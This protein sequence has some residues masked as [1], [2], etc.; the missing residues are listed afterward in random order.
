MVKKKH[1]GSKLSDFLEEDG[2]KDDVDLLTFKK[3]F[4][5]EIEH[6]MAALNFTTTTL[7]K[8][9]DTSRNQVLRILDGADIGISFKTVADVARALSS[10]FIEV[11]ASTSKKASHLR[12]PPKRSPP[13]QR[14]NTS[15]A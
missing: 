7:A 4:A 9:M 14:R 10:N 11:M 12:T 3:V 13:R 1:I 15:A 8:K 6:R 5:A 2:I